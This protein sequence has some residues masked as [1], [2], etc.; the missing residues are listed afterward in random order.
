[1][2]SKTRIFIPIVLSFQISYFLRNNKT[3]AALLEMI[4]NILRIKCL[5]FTTYSIDAPNILHP[6]INYELVTTIRVRDTTFNYDV[7]RDLLVIKPSE[8][9]F[10]S[11]FIDTFRN[12]WWFE[13]VNE[14]CSHSRMGGRTILCFQMESV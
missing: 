9:S 10:H 8:S 1:M 3:K 2:W 4:F 13:N 12:F 5:T 11:L 7:H 6:E 14:S